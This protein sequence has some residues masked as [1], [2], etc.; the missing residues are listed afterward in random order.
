[1]KLLST[2]A[3]LLASVF[4]SAQNI[5]SDWYG[6]WRG[7]LEIY[8][9]QGFQQKVKMGLNINQKT[10]STWTWQLI[11][12]EGEKQDFRDYE[13]QKA[14]DPGQ[15]IIDEKNSILLYLS[16][17]DNTFYSMFELNNTRLIISYELKADQIIFKTLSSPNQEPLKSGGTSPQIPEVLTRKVT[18]AQIAILN[19]K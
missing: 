3:F 11:Y 18:S 14:D 1:M 4:C 17:V 6:E 15:Y 10:D 7:E 16:L 5:T 12:G 8:N 13:L 19:K 9:V 2:L